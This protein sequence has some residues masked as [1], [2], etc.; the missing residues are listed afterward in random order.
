MD[1]PTSLQPPASLV[2][3]FFGTFRRGRF[4]AWRRRGHL[5]SLLWPSKRS[6]AGWWNNVEELVSLRRQLTAAILK[7]QKLLCRQSKLGKSPIIA[8]DWGWKSYCSLVVLPK[9]W[10]DV[11]KVVNYP[12]KAT[13]KVLWLIQPHSMSWHSH[14]MLES[15][16]FKLRS[17]FDGYSNHQTHREKLNVPLLLF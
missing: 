10:R 14:L 3:A 4:S 13:P 12:P 11:F 5:R 8:H 1:T 15:P 16:W 9:D 7:N 2:P 6:G 17:P